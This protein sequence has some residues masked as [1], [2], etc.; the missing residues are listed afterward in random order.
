MTK[1]LVH[2]DLFTDPAC[3]FG[4]SAE[5]DILA[6]K[7]LYGDQL[8]WNTRFVV[9]SEKVGENEAKGLTVEMI[10]AGRAMLREKYRMPLGTDKLPHM[11]VAKPADMAIK[12]VQLN[13][14]A[15]ADRFTRALRVAWHSDA[16]PIDDQNV[17]LEVASESGIDRGA[18][19]AWL[20]QPEVATALESDKVAARSP[21][22]AALVLDH[23]LA[24]PDDERRYTCPSFEFAPLDDLEDIHSVP[25]F[26][27]LLTYEAAIANTVP[28]IVR[29]APALD[30][31]D[32]LEWA[33]WPL[34]TVEVARV[35]G[36]SDEV[37]E[38]AL[39][40]TD[41]INERGYWSMPSGNE[42][43]LAAGP[44]ATD[45]LVGSPRIG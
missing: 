11:L 20:E 30:P 21:H 6:L 38:A 5:P 15:K 42:D 29:A 7:W 36:V 18:L 8:E 41:A 13:E 27:D 44:A 26:H 19:T 39:A 22:P 35:M 33:D 1:G 40:A 43:Q 4:F 3:P 24:G 34:A 45:R 17:I 23:K 9:L 16:R 2:V 10:E 31:L 14:P 12:A 28:S 25:G 37:A 32:V